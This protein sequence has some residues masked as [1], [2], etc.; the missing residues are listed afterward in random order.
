[1][2]SWVEGHPHVRDLPP[3]SY[4][5]DLTL[6]DRVIT[7]KLLIVVY[8]GDRLNLYTTDL[9]LSD[10]EVMRTWKIRWEIE[11]LHKDIKALG[12]QDSSSRGRGCKVTCPSS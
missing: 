1:M 10:E 4:L 5:A 2:T 8:K 7:V 3:G 12:V 6:G 9:D 11:E